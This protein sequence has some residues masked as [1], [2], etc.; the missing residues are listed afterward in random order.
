MIAI[1]ASG[2]DPSL[3][4]VHT[5]GEGGFPGLILGGWFGVVVPAATPRAVIDRIAADLA[6][7][8]SRQDIRE[9]T[10]TRVG[11]EPLLQGPEQFA[12]FIREE[13]ARYSQVIKNLN[14]KLD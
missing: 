8:F 7:I 9:R 1:T 13:R 3:P 4:E 11:L 2:R 12:E 10:I 14:L 6:Q 5:A